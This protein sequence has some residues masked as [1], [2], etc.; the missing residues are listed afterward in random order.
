VRI[1][2]QASSNPIKPLSFAAGAQ[3]IEFAKNAQKRIL[4][5]D[6]RAESRHLAAI[7]GRRI[8]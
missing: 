6:R 3:L 2:L 5:V 4:I 1:Q 7:F 8:L